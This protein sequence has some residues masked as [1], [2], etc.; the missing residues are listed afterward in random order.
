MCRKYIFLIR[1]LPNLQLELHLLKL[2]RIVVPEL[3]VALRDVVLR[4]L[5]LVSKLLR[6]LGFAGLP[7]LAAE[8]RYEGEGLGGRGL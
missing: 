6:H 5:P 4:E 8:S 3:V 2:I 1:Q 7:L